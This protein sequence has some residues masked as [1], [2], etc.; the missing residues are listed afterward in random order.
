[1]LT[2]FQTL[3]LILRNKENSALKFSLGRMGL[4]VHPN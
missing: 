2:S 1:M 4:S 3:S